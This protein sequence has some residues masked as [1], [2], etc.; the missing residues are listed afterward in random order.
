MITKDINKNIKVHTITNE[1]LRLGILLALVGGFLESYTFITRDGVFA[2]AQTGNIVLVGVGLSMKNWNYAI[3]H[4][5]PVIAFVLGVLTVEII[6]SHDG[7]AK[8]K[9]TERIIILVEIIILFVIGFIPLD[10]DDTVVTVTISYVASLQ[11][12]SFRKLVNSPYST[13]MCTGNLRTATQTLYLAIKNKDT[14]GKTK[15]LRYFTIVFS[16]ILGGCIGGIT[17]NYLGVKSIWCCEVFLILAFILFIMDEY[18]LK[19]GTM[20]LRM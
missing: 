1:S 13:A 3:L 10:F 4:L 19:N 9:Y 20:V 14:K 2:N 8:S 6:K 7:I 17:T 12:A 18:R 5:L 11:I 16:F 15:A